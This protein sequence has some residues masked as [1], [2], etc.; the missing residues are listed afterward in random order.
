MEDEAH[1]LGAIGEPAVGALSSL[2][3]SKSEWCRINAAFAL[4]E[5]DSFGRGAVRD[6]CRVS[7]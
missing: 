3:S 4:G 1:A 2:L 7:P 6:L 5:M